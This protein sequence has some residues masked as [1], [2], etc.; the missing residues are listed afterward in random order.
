MKM[1]AWINNEEI[2]FSEGETVLQAATRAGVFIPTL[3]AF[4]PLDHT[5]GT[6]RM[7][8][9]EISPGADGSEKQIVTACTTPLVEGMRVWTRTAEVRRLQRMQV[10][11][12]FADHDQ[13][14]A[15]CARYG[16]C[17][18]QDLALYVGLRDNTCNGRF[19]VARPD[20]WSATG[21]VRD[22]NKCVRCCRCINV[23]R[24][25]Q[26][27]SALTLDKIG[28][29]SGVG[30]AGAVRWAESSLCV[31]C[32]QCTL[33][34]PTGALSEH[35]QIEQVVDWLDDPEIKTVVAFAPAVRVTIGDEFGLPAG[36]DTERKINTDPKRLGADYVC[37]INWAADVTIME[38][39]TELLHRLSTG[40]GLPMMTSCCPGWVNYVE[41]LHPEL[42]ENLSST[43]SPQGIFGS[44]VK[45]WFAREHNI[46]P[47]KLRFISLMPCTA[48]KDEAAR[49]Q[50]KKNGL[51]DTD[52]VLTV[53]EFA[54]L[55][56]RYGIN[57]PELPDGEYDSPFMAQNS[58]AGAIFGVTGGV[59]EAAVRTV[60]HTVTGRELEGICFEPARGQDWIREAEVDLGEKGR[61]RVAVVHGL[62][63]VPK[64]LERINSGEARYDFVEVMACPGGCVD[65]GG[66]VRSKF[67]YLQFARDRAHGIYKIDG[68]RKI[69]QSHNNPDVVRLYREFLEKPMSEK[70]EELLH[71][72]YRDRKQAPR[73][74]TITEIWRDV[75][76]G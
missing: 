73:R 23:C 12:I 20:D 57:L 66:T 37:D 55:L 34:C 47:E 36:Q 60:Y 58:G 35:D 38:E 56:H 74:R 75:Q 19:K 44:L 51:P 28:T 53:R 2:E 50:L 41:K 40:K 32:G 33:V 70:A 3:C 1:K 52:V 30:V 25:V 27:I 64:L 24:R 21:V 62:V 67:N 14:C 29:E 42:L 11:W 76:L 71:T 63:N 17:E 43:R 59:M 4:M 10:A 26:G 6:C 72:T 18:L 69:R 31:Q 13:D 8:L 48:K 5:P 7:C 39:G 16:N 68:E 61:V 54:R 22:A 15:S 45:T 9:V 46:D 65:G 49:E